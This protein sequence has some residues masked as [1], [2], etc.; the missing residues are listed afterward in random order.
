MKTSVSEQKN[1]FLE[2]FARIPMSIKIG[3]MT[4]MLLYVVLINMEL[5]AG[6][7]RYSLTVVSSSPQTQTCLEKMAAIEG[8][9]RLLKDAR[10]AGDI[11]KVEREKMHIFSKWVSCGVF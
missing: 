4:L 2:T 1:L 11:I 9:M 10:T 6:S 8:E 5:S 7:Q 3:V